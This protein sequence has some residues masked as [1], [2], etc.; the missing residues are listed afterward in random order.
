MP[1]PPVP[2]PGPGGG[3]A[4][5]V[6]TWRREDRGGNLGAGAQPGAPVPPRPAAPRAR[7]GAWTRSQGPGARGGRG[8]TGCR[9]AAFPPDGAGPQ[10]RGRGRERCDC[11]GLSYSKWKQMRESCTVFFL[12][13]LLFYRE[14]NKKKI[15]RREVR[16]R[17][18]P[19]SPGPEGAGRRRRERP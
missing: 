14:Q 10:P 16:A 19:A 18:R 2:P 13:R 17:P 7:R 12:S 3:R 15:R 6:S 8:R 5:G 9:E 11:L 4:E 1:G